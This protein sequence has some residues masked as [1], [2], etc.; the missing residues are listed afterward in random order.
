VLGVDTNVLVRF[1]AK[2]DDVQT[3]QAA[4]VLTANG[5]HPIYVGRVV[6]VETFWVLTKVKK[7]PRQQVI[8]SFRGLLS[9][10]DFKVEAEELVGRA[11][12]DCERVGCDFADAL[13]ALENNHAGCEATLTF[14]TDAYPLD[15][16]VPLTSRLLR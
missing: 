13:I 1:L 3:P 7:F 8:D 15:D 5:N 10:V 4:E 11:L 6:A 14:D 12:D 16:M 9:S 2:D